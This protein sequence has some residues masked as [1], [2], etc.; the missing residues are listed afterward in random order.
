MTRKK[1]D[2]TRPRT[3][4][5]VQGSKK[6]VFKPIV[7]HPTKERS[8]IIRS[9]THRC[10][11]PVVIDG[12]ASCAVAKMGRRR[13]AVNILNDLS[14]S[15]PMM[16]RPSITTTAF[17]GIE[18]IIASIA[19]RA[20]KNAHVGKGRMLMHTH[21]QRAFEDYCQ[22]RGGVWLGV[23]KKY[24]VMQDAI[25]SKENQLEVDDVLVM[26]QYANSQEGIHRSMIRQEASGK[27]RETK[28]VNAMSQEGIE[29]SMIRAE[30]R[31]KA[32]EAKRVNRAKKMLVAIAQNK[33]I[34]EEEK[35]DI[36]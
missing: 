36:E 16:V 21:I 30:A 28:R 5:S 20:Q 25:N 6:T 32:N 1:S 19:E 27:A 29:R 18:S 11:V 35:M 17:R 24:H 13:M 23:M 2:V 26:K 8:N 22:A 34:I 9:V 14:P 31:N 10:R 12:N 33:S 7:L 15:Q 4:A 3:A